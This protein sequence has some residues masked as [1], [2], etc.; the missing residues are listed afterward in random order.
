MSQYVITGTFSE[1]MEP[2]TINNTT[3]TAA[4]GVTGTVALDGTGR[5]AT[6]TPWK[7][8]R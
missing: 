5:I 6:F 4:P 7:A 3:V 1:A 2:A 8:G